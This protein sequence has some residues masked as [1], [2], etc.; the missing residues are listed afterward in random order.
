MGEGSSGPGSTLPPG[1]GD[2]ETTP[3]VPSREP[4]TQPWPRPAGPEPPHPPTY[5]P[6]HPAT[7]V[8]SYP[9]ADAPQQPATVMRPREPQAEAVPHEPVTYRPP[10]QPSPDAGPPPPGA[11]PS[12]TPPSEV[13][14]Y[15]PGVP[16][17]Q[18]GA[19]AESVWRTGQRPEPPP[20]QRRLRRLRRLLGMALTVIL[21]VA[22]GIV[23]YLR[24][25]DHPSLHV[26]GVK[27]TQQTRTGCTVDVTGRIATNG[28]AG[29]V[30]YQWVFRPQTQAPQPL[31]Q[32][33][34]AGQHAVFVTVAVEGQGHG[35][36]TQTVTLDVLGPDAGSDST[37][38]TI[39]C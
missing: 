15:G 14:R 39:S 34:V 9:P 35:S 16:A 25:F 3:I 24:F 29:T 31:N 4:A 1:A 30:S 26:T 36:A 13:Q 28:S 20:R 7:D 32:S 19:A 33:V 17:S 38:V 5:V 27:I 11:G 12:A 8:P 21:L 22:A 10:R 2:S 6:P 23:L 37:N 18:A